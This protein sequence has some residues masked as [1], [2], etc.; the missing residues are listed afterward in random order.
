MIVL[1]SSK[2]QALLVGFTLAPAVVPLGEECVKCS[3]MQRKVSF[4]RYI[5][6]ALRDACNSATVYRRIFVQKFVPWMSYAP[7]HARR[8]DIA[9]GFLYFLPRPL[10]EKRWHRSA[11]CKGPT[12]SIP[13]RCTRREVLAFATSALF[14]FTSP[15]H[16]LARVQT[17]RLS[18][19]LMSVVRVRDGID[20]L[21]N[22]I[23]NGATN[24]DI[25]RIVET[26]VKGSAVKK[27]TEEAA[28]WIGR[29]GSDAVS[30]AQ[31]ALEFLDQVSRYFDAT[32]TR[33]K[34]GPE[35]LQFSLQ[36]LKAAKQ[37]LDVV[38]DL[39]PNDQISAAREALYSYKAYV[40][41]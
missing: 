9:M 34:V 30:H 13:Y 21:A 24:G 22:E 12:M 10:M 37:E 18:E 17:R 15:V 31:T 28:L 29:N 7:C 2:I 27:D 23:E 14:Y 41:Q 3:R 33:E 35:A 19:T 5:L 16:I 39:F 6:F 1:L 11:T 8:H 32:G 25:R 26:L 36:A 40:P 4:A 38:L 20:E